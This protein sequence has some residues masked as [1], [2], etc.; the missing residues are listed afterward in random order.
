MSTE[1]TS[2][3]IPLYPQTK[4]RITATYHAEQVG[5]VLPAGQPDSVDIELNELPE[6]I[7]TF[8]IEVVSALFRSTPAGATSTVITH[9]AGHGDDLAERVSSA[10]RANSELTQRLGAAR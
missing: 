6:D 3:G 10:T 5:D 8:I 9:Q 2:A 7:S 4:L 1:T